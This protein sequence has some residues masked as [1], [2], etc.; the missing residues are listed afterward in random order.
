MLPRSI[1]P[2]IPGQRFF[3]LHAVPHWGLHSQ[4]PLLSMRGHSSAAGQWSIWVALRL[5]RL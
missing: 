2:Q 1:V 5:G 3:P 4:T